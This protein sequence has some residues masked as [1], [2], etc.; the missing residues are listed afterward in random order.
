MSK[1]IE[2]NGNSS[3][4]VT[5]NRIYEHLKDE[6][7]SGKLSAGEP[8]KQAVIA[9]N[10]NVSAIPVR[11]AFK[12]LQA[13]GLVEIIER[14]GAVV[15]TV[16]IDEVLQGLSIRYS[17]EPLALSWA[18]PNLSIS[19]IEKAKELKKRLDNETDVYQHV[20]LNKE[21]HLTLIRPCQ[22]EPLTD[23]IEA[24]FNRHIISPQTKLLRPSDCDYANE[25]HE[26]L[27]RHCEMFKVFE[28]T[29]C[30]KAHINQAKLHINQTRKSL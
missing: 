22:F 10:N 25:N 24:L 12:M 29:D 21:L 27:I 8:L 17:L 6:I 30:L 13:D 20:L 26:E 18:I 15:R 19:E 23:F 4:G 16:S 9:K 2:A 3:Y 14:R 11:E 7:L 5:A 1:E 28:A